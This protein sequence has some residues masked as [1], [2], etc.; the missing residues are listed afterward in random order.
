MFKATFRNPKNPV[1]AEVLY[2]K[3]AAEAV[4]HEIVSKELSELK[5]V[6]K[7]PDYFYAYEEA[8]QCL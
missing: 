3:T 1:D 7:V 2:F 4:S 8:R 5:K 6:N